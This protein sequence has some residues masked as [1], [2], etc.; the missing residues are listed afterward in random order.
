M[1]SRVIVF[2]LCLVSAVAWKPVSMKVNVQRALPAALLSAGLFFGGA[3]ESQTFDFGVVKAAMADTQSVFVGSYDDPNHPGCLRKI[4]V[5][6]TDVT[7]LG[8]DAIDG[9]NQWRISAKEDYPG[10][11]FVDFSPKG[12]PKNLLGVYNDREE[13]IKWP[14][15]NM[16]KKIKAPKV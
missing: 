11:I 7:I 5:K 1:I 4:T 9:S 13:G 2:I 10:T 15:G 14:D 8:S 3:L 12:G 6:G 16:W